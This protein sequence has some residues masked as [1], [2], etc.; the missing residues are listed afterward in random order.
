MGFG[1][2]TILAVLSY[3]LARPDEWPESSMWVEGPHGDGGSVDV[4]MVPF[5]LPLFGLFLG[6]VVFLYQKAKGKV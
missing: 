1:I 3:V 6:L 2:G 5:M 4:R